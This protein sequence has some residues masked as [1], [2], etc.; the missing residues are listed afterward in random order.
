MVAVLPVTCQLNVL[1]VSAGVMET[2]LSIPASICCSDASHVAAQFGL[3]FVELASVIFKIVG[4]EAGVEVDDD[5]DEVACA[6][7]LLLTAPPHANNVM[8][9]AT[10]K[11]HISIRLLGMLQTPLAWGV[12]RVRQDPS[13][14]GAT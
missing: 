13:F 1:P 3:L 10:A 9:S 12:R 11:T 6:L 4:A 7:G 2:Q 8:V 14:K 5:D